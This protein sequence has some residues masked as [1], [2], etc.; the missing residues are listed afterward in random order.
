MQ[1]PVEMGGCEGLRGSTT[2]DASVKK[3]LL[4][5]NCRKVY[6]RLAQFC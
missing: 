6:N 3:L 5:L 4:L 1:Q 2:T